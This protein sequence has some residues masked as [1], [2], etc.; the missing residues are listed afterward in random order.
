MVKDYEGCNIKDI[1]L[2]FKFSFSYFS[3]L[4]ISFNKSDD[5]SKQITLKYMLFFFPFVGLIISSLTVLLYISIEPSWLM[6]I[7]CSTLYMLFYGFLHT[8]AIADVADALYASHSGKDAYNIIKEPTIGAMGLLYTVSFFILKIASLTFIFLNNL[9]FELIVIT[10]FSRLSIV[11]II[12]LNSF[13][14]SFVSTLK[15]SFTKFTLIIATF[16][17]L[18]IAFSLIDISFLYLGLITIFTSYLFIKYLRKKLGFLN[19]DVLGA[20]LELNELIM[21]I[22][23]ASI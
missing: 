22:T 14:S 15:N 6:A 12:Y 5:L 13:K 16:I 19:G 9:Y 23:I 8:E 10:I 1:Y 21:L 2:G 7:L 11:Y 18:A 20:N 3:I 17:Y 4:P